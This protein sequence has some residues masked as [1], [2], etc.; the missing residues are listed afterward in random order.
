MISSPNFFS[1]ARA[2]VDHAETTSSKR[3]LP[4]PSQEESQEAGPS[5]KRSKGAQAQSEK[6]LSC[7][8]KQTEAV[9]SNTP[10]KEEEEENA[11]LDQL[12]DHLDQATQDPGEGSS[13]Q[14][15]SDG[16]S[17][18]S[19]GRANSNNPPP[20]PPPKSPTPPIELEV[21]DEDPYYH[22]KMAMLAKPTR[23]VR[24]HERLRMLNVTCRYTGEPDTYLRF[25]ST[26]LKRKEDG[27]PWKNCHDVHWT[28]LR[29]YTNEINGYINF[30]GIE[31]PTDG[32]GEGVNGYVEGEGAHMNIQA[33]D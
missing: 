28:R 26:S 30:L 9:A 5:P 3:N 29:R 16:L 31:D 4:I 33:N 32:A 19:V 25:E 11:R 21:D 17:K 12:T 15:E 23:V 13:S 1:G 6:N 22:K 18:L 24:I 8:K 7:P 20:P 27:T 2:A 10:L 14:K